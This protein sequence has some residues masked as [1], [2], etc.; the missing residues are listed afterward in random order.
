M[1]LLLQSIVHEINVLI[2][3]LRTV[4]VY[5]Y[6]H[7]YIIHTFSVCIMYVCKYVA[8]LTYN[9]S[10]EESTRAKFQVVIALSQKYRSQKVV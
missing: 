10:R 2:A 8:L 5:V 3:L 7:T 9:M 4:C 1:S 6:L